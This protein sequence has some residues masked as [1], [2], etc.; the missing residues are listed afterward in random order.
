MS[1]NP[2]QEQLHIFDFFQNGTGNGMIDAVAGSG[3][4]STIIKGIDYI[5]S[6]KRILFCAFNKKIQEEIAAKTKDRDNVVVRTT[7]AL[8]LAILRRNITAIN[9]NPKTDNS[10]YYNILNDSLRKDR[11]NNYVDYNTITECFERIRSKYYNEKKP[12]EVDIFFKTFNT[13]YHRLAE[14]LRYTLSYNKGEHS[15]KRLV[16]KYSIDIDPED[17]VLLELYRT[18]LE[19]AIAEGNNKAKSLGIYDF[20]DM[21]FLPCEFRLR[22]QKQFDVVFVDECQDLSNAQLKIIR[23]YLNNEGRLFAVGDPYQ[24][25]YGFAGAS[26]ESFTNIQSIFEPRMFKLTNCFR[27]SNK[28]VQLA[29]EIRSDITTTNTFPSEIKKIKFNEI[30]KYIQK[31]DFILSRHNSSLFEVVFELLKKDIKFKII[32]KN[33]ILKSLKNIIPNSAFDNERYYQELPNHLD[34]IYR[35]AE[36]KLSNNPANYEKLENL[37]D[38]INILETCFFHNDDATTL[39][40]LFL[41]IEGLMDSDDKDSVMLSSIHR[42]KGLERK[43]VFIIGYEKLPFKREDM[44]DW[45][46]YQEK[47]LKYVAITRAEV[48]LYQTE[49]PPENDSNIESKQFVLEDECDLD[50][51]I[52]NLPL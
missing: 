43:N 31:Q 35:S 1:F 23:K 14:L 39:N 22:P 13:N 34:Q 11:N 19:T 17:K 36:A 3:K 10:K 8:G 29:K 24:S 6:T 40:D 49:S 38:S 2:T 26:P 44:M 25:I 32:G 51:T 21:I 48:T 41:Y 15:F 9:N 20:A 52:D 16:E 4:T 7:Y 18:L 50:N 28:I 30:T 27:C 45:Q 12:D 42:A 33:E 47:C 5:S 37:N 46:I